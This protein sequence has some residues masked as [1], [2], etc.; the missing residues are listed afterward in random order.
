MTDAMFIYNRTS[1]NFTYTVNDPR[2]ERVERVIIHGSYNAHMSDGHSPYG[3]LTVVPMD[4]FE[5]LKENSSFQR[6]KEHNVIVVSDVDKLEP[7]EPQGDIQEPEPEPEPEEA[8]A[9][10]DN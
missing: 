7:A 9:D 5:M 1:G 8:K 2:S 4:I 3:V 6:H 10:G